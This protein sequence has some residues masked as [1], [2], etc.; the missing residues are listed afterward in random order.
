MITPP[1]FVSTFHFV[2]RIKCTKSGPYRCNVFERRAPTDIPW[3]RCA[4]GASRAVQGSLCPRY[5]ASPAPHFVHPP[6]RRDLPTR[7]K[8]SGPLSCGVLT[9]P[10][11]WGAWHQQRLPRQSPSSQSSACGVS[12]LSNLPTWQIPLQLPFAPGTAPSC[13]A[14]VCLLGAPARRSWCAAPS[15]TVCALRPL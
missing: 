7:C 14:G 15:H 9:M 10:C 8:S 6:T 2:S 3:T 5:S 11:H 13:T 12:A 4:A 1:P